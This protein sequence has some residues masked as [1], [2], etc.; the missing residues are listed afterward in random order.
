M[1]RREGRS[2]RMQGRRGKRRQAHLALL[3]HPPRRVGYR[4]EC[5]C[6]AGSPLAVPH[7][8]PHVPRHHSPGLT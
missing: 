4:S 2:G 5:S 6:Q 1:R 8:R 3:V 7:R